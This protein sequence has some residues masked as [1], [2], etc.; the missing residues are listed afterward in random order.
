MRRKHPYAQHLENRVFTPQKT[1]HPQKGNH[2]LLGT[3]VLA[4]RINVSCGPYPYACRECFTFRTRNSMPSNA[5][6]RFLCLINSNVRFMGIVRRNIQV[7]RHH[8]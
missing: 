6:Y 8:A 5:H 2:T 7:P 4:L 1:Q 3:S